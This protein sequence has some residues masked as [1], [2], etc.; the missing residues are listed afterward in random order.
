[1][2]ENIVSYMEALMAM[3]LMEQLYDLITPTELN[4]S[5]MTTFNT[6]HSI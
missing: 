2:D 5:H 6:W 3:S 4:C 1:M